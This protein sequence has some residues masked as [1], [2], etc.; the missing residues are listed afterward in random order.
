MNE[1]LKRNRAVA[2]TKD[3]IYGSSEIPFFNRMI[4]DPLCQQDLALNCNSDTGLQTSD[5]RLFYYRNLTQFYL[6]ISKI[7]EICYSNIHF[8]SLRT[9]W[10]FPLFSLRSD[11]YSLTV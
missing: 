8:L 6:G 3:K 7:G 4:I 10:P 11:V 2:P 5:T 9:P 1:Y